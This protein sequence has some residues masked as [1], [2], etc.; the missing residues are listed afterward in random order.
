MSMPIIETLGSTPVIASANAEVPHRSKDRHELRLPS[1]KALG[2]AV[3][4]PDQL[5]TP[6]AESDQ[7]A[8]HPMS[9]PLPHRQD[10]ENPW[11]MTRPAERMTPEDD[12][13][14]PVPIDSEN[15]DPGSGVT[16]V[17]QVVE[18][19]ETDATMRHNSS[20]SEGE[21]T[22]E[23]MWFEHAVDAVVST[24]PATG[25]SSNVVVTLCHAQPCPLSTENEAG[26]NAFKTLITTLQTKLEPGQFI[27]ITYAVPPKFNMELLPQS[28]MATPNATSGEGDYFSMNVF[29][30]AVAAVDHSTA[31][32]SSIPSSPR[33]VV[34]PSTVSITCLE[35]FIPPSTAQEYA[36]L[37]SIDRPSVLVDRLTELSPQGGNLIFIYPTHLGAATFTSKYVNPLLDP[38]LRTMIQIHGLSA[39]LGRDVGTMAAVPQMLAFEPMTRRISTLLKRLGRMPQGS[40][41]QRPQYTLVQWSK[42]KVDL[43]RDVWMEWWT[44]QETPRIKEVMKNYFKRGSRLPQSKEKTESALVWEILD[45]MKVREYA[46]SDQPTEGI[47][48]GVFVIKRTA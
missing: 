47:E 23:P 3:P 27:E 25:S 13:T 40:M 10:Y 22:G 30:K 6:P 48:V 38:L 14:I 4:H 41:A 16:S 21:S 34:P 32:K 36:D 39:D 45:K 42:E 15:V 31:I 43:E 5:L 8:W 12:Q 24:V 33:P 11:S 44:H 35:R 26:P 20:S 18:P 1:F 17:P 2:I 37:F 29:S 7:I 19:E 46:P 28:P 9:Q